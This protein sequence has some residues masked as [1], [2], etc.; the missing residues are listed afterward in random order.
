MV[1]EMDRAAVQRVRRFNRTV[2]ERINALSDR[3]LGRGRPMGESRVLWEIGLDG[4]EVREL[5]A[6]LGLDSGYT[7]RM[8]RSLGRPTADQGRGES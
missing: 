8:L 7:S 3:F 1:R 2:A 6:Q 4:K 5:R